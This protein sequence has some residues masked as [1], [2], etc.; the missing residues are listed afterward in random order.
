MGRLTVEFDMKTLCS[1][2]T[3]R[4]QLIVVAWLLVP[5]TAAAQTT[6]AE[7]TR[8]EQAAKLQQ[9]QPPGPDSIAER[10][11]DRLE[12]WG[13]LMGAP[14]GV[15]PWV[16][17]VYPGGGLAGGAGVRKPLG[18]DGALNVFGGYSINTFSR[19]QAD[20]QLPTFA[21]NRARITFS[22]RYVD[23]PDVRHFGVGN[24]SLRE[25]ETRFGYTPK[26]G[27]VRLEIEGRRFSIGGSADYYD[28]ETSGGRTG[29]S[30]EER[31]SAADTPGLE[32]SDFV[33]LKSTAHAAF[34]WRK[35]LG[36]SG[37]GGLYRLRFD[38]YREADEVYSFQ[39]VEA[40]VVQLI[41]ILR[42]N[43]VIA[44]RG[45][46]TVT[47]IDDSSAVPFFLLPSLGGGSTLRG[48]PDFRFR[49][50]NRL[51]MNAELRWTPARFMDMA[52]FYDTGK[53]AAVREE[54]NFEDLKESYG[55]GMRIVGTDGYALRLEVA[56]SREHRARLI[57]G[58]AGSF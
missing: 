19:A 44:L 41:P 3:S 5:L 16:G 2:G 13:L 20:L 55:I 47:D 6:R 34:D 54:L 45:L 37:Q 10:I 21:Q 57:V 11:V 17:S 8:Q 48:Y 32:V 35:P 51:L 31:F 14:R 40:E 30:I 53:V 42:A 49:D 43:W 22:G 7:I 58:V 15:Y 4:L 25:D 12:D 39:S 23:A 29:P 1:A 46:A 26:S 9:I 28:I 33:Y 56:H 38:D 24:S 18:D 36:Y 50:R 27:G 52:V